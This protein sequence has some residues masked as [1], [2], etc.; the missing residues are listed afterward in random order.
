MKLILHLHSKCNFIS[1]NQP[2][3]QS[4]I[5]QNDPL[6]VGKL[7]CPVSFH[8]YQGTSAKTLNPLILPICLRL[9]NDI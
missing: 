4:L 1:V 5:D 2:I 7:K 3:F 8:G 9:F 6:C